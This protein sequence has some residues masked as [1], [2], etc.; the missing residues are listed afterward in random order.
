MR[1]L[2]KTY[3]PFA[4]NE[5][6]RILSY[7][8]NVLMFIIGDGLILLATYFLWRAIYQSSPEQ[9]INGFTYSEMIIYV[10]MSFMVAGLINTDIGYSVSSEVKDG[11]IAMNLIRPISFQMRMLFQSIGGLLYNFLVIFLGASIFIT[12]Y[13][14]QNQLTFTL[15]QIITFFLSIVFGFLL[16]FFFMYGFGLLAFKLTNMWGMS[17]I[18]GAIFNLLSGTLIPIAFFPLW[19]QPLFNFLPFS[20]MIYTPTMIYLGKL[21]EMEIVAALGLQ[22]VWIVILSTISRMLWK[23][24]IKQLVILGG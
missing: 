23:T 4:T 1:K 18:I 16:N 21:T 17:Q 24:L 6:Q 20:S 2:L 19:A 3:L 15:F 22:L 9:I 10:L 7:K 14:L 11:S 5:F 12:F 13:A 8:A